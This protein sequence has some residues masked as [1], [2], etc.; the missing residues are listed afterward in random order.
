M[1]TVVGVLSGVY[2][3]KPLI[4]RFLYE[5]DSDVQN[6]LK[7]GADNENQLCCTSE[8]SSGVYTMEQ[9]HLSGV[10]AIHYIQTEYQNESEWMLFLSHVGDPRNA[11]LVYFPLSYA[12]HSPTGRAVMWLA[13]LSE[14][15]NGILKWFLH[16]H[17]PYWWVHGNSHLQRVPELQ[18]YRLTC[19][20]GP[21]SPSGHAMVTSAVLAA[22][23]SGLLRN[24]RILQNIRPVASVIL[25][26]LFA[27]LMAAVCV[28]RCFIATH[29]PHQVVAGVGTGV[30]MNYGFSKLPPEVFTVK[31]HVWVACAIL[32][33]SW[34]TYTALVVVG[35]DPF[36]SVGLAQKWCAD[37]HW[38]HLDTTVFNALIRDFACLLGF[39]LGQALSSNLNFRDSGANT[40][41]LHMLSSTV[42]ALSLFAFTEHYI[43]APQ[44]IPSLFYFVTFAKYL[45]VCGVSV[46]VVRWLQNTKV[47][48][49]EGN[50]GK[51]S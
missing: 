10:D 21:G 19:E 33:T 8:G 7:G 37:S 1:V 15:L 38:I 42:V 48:D 2:I 28:S 51:N 32:V 36:W 40:S 18:Q 35:I 30:L 49:T 6:R 34:L 41:W 29:F 47:K 5:V 46:V 27:L 4:E 45:T 22:M 3:W 12:L 17:R 25:W 14:W 24:A 44:K 39:G 23:V 31:N 20:T 16:G 43:K 50:T 11:F 9:L 13:A 26:L